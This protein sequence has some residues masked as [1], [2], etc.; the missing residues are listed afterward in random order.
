M[1]AEAAKNKYL[2][3]AVMPTDASA[4]RK[5]TLSTELSLQQLWQRR[6]TIGCWITLE[7]ARQ[8]NDQPTTQMISTGAVTAGHMGSTLLKSVI[9]L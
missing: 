5:Q 9:N 3:A 2:M 1:T 4:E 6:L 8:S 7:R